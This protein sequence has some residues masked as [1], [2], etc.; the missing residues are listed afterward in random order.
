MGS[1]HWSTSAK[2]VAVLLCL[3]PRHGGAEQQIPSL[4][5]TVVLDQEASLFLHLECLVGGYPCS[6]EPYAELW[7]SALDQEQFDE[8]VRKW[9][10]IMGRYDIVAPSSDA[11]TV[12]YPDLGP[13]SGFRLRWTIQKVMVSADSPQERAR[14]LRFLMQSEDVDSLFQLMTQSRQVFDP[15]WH[16]HE[17][18]WRALKDAIA[19]A[20][21]DEIEELRK[22]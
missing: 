8:T 2:L 14:T 21:N 3:L 5:V 6:P 11:T 15:W 12:L 1:I 18:Q 20:A 19:V 22:V 17:T 9:Q 4:P 13:D 7:R 16:Q 10:T